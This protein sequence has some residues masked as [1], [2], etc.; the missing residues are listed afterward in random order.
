MIES[1]VPKIIP[2]VVRVREDRASGSTAGGRLRVLFW[3]L[4]G[5]NSKRKI[6][7][8]VKAKPCPECGNEMLITS[9]RCRECAY[10]A[11]KA[12]ADENRRC[13]CGSLKSVPRAEMC[14][15]C[16]VEVSNGR[17]NVRRKQQINHCQECGVQIGR[18]SNKC[19]RCYWKSMK[20]PVRKCFGCQ[21]LGP[22][23]G[24]THGLCIKCDK[25]R[26]K[27]YWHKIGKYKVDRDDAKKAEA[28][29]RERNRGKESLRGSAW[30]KNNPE[31]AS[32][33]T[34][35][36]NERVKAAGV[37]I[38][39][40]QFDA[41]KA[42]YGYSC[43]CCGKKEPEIKLVADHVVPLVSG[44]SNDMSNRQPLCFSCNS[45]KHLATTD[46]RLKQPEQSATL[47]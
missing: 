2:G 18:G 1:F 27:E 24:P 42:T 33:H 43:L 5:M 47:P 17:K 14:W 9:P 46:Y 44:G 34:K 39:V 6:K 21:S 10:K 37:D 31:K 30:V 40:E 16:W 13:K 23:Y 29:Y 36:R 25:E 20:N 15:G 22:F 12:M 3:R 8:H 26:A 35:L 19:R 41:L 11:K 38:T 28:R 32:A 7:G 45:K 4:D